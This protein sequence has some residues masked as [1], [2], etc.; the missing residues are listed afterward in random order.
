MAKLDRAL[1]SMIQYCKITVC[2]S[3]IGK[4]FKY[5]FNAFLYLHNEYN[6]IRFI[7]SDGNAIPKP[8]SS[9]QATKNFYSGFVVK[10]NSTTMKYDRL[11]FYSVVHVILS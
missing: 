1:F 10:L 8:K 9:L 2:S 5:Y 7:V 6:F 4:N 3:L 11:Q